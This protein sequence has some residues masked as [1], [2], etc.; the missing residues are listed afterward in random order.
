MFLRLFLL[1]TLIPAI[2]LYL[3]IK[4]G[5]F[6]GAGNTILLIIGTGI[7]G[8]YYARQQGLAVMTSIQVR[9]QQG[10]LP[11]D[12]LVNGAMLLVGG[13]LLITPGFL[14]D[15]AGFSLIFPP[16]REVIKVAVKG[17]LERKARE[18]Q[19]IINRGH[20][21]GGPFIDV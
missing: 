12:D 8:A 21:D 6:I 16:T 17:W 14:T 3:L 18:G 20:D 9:M 15:I 7:L 11:G 5:A 13:A 2:E 19:V 10:R 1:F 4:V